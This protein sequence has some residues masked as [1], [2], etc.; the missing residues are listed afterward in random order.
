MS[1]HALGTGADYSAAIGLTA[2][3]HYKARGWVEDIPLS[4]VVQEGLE[5]LRAG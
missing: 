5:M 3:A 1:G 2:S 4:G